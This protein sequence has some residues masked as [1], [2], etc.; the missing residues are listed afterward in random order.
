[1]PTITQQSATMGRR[2]VLLSLLAVAITMLGVSASASAA[3]PVNGCPEGFALISVAQA[4][5][6]GY[7]LGRISDESMVKPI[8]NHDGYACR[9]PLGDGVFRGFPGRPD[10]IYL[11]YDNWLL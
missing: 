9:R 5:S 6:E 2:R 11:W 8:G 7:P 4:D 3:P 1:M 10:T